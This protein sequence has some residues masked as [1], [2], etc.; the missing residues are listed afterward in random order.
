MS[1]VIEDRTKSQIEVFTVKK[2]GEIKE[3]KIDHENNKYKE[4]LIKFALKKD[5]SDMFHQLF[6][7][8]QENLVQSYPTYVKYKFGLKEKL[9]IYR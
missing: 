6:L 4:Q 2:A 7:E 5:A 3:Q 1:K 8:S 9:K